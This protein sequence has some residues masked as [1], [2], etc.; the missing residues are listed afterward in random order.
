MRQ[1]ILRSFM[2]DC[3]KVGEKFN[4]ET[5]KR[6]RALCIACVNEIIQKTQI[7]MTEAQGQALI[8]S[9]FREK[10]VTKFWHPSKFR[11][12]RDTMKSFRELPDP[13]LVIQA[14]DICFVDVG[15]IIED[16]E[17]DYG[18]TF[19]VG[20]Q[21]VDHLIQSCHEVFLQTAQAW[22]NK[23]LTGKKLY[24]FAQDLT[25]K[26]GYELNPL[27]AGHRLGDFPHKIF[28]SQKLNEFE[29]SPNENLWILEIHIVDKKN[30]RGAFFE[31]LLSEQ[32]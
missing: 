20:S 31:D 22:K 23:K 15:P 27:M 21:E 29:Y 16:H 13:N 19:I 28:S 2:I 32:C 4:L 12:A 24:Q 7:G 26:Y 10:G 5:F 6:A 18:Q 11:I 17:A 25:E 3:E 30:N 9:V 1:G 8:Q 14:H